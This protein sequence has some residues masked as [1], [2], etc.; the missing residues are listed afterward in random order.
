MHGWLVIDKPVGP[1]ST[2]SSSAGEAG[3]ARGRLS[4]RQG[5]AWRHARSAGERRA[6]GGAR[7]GDQARRADA[8]ADKRTIHDP[9]REETSTWTRKESGCALRVRPSSPR[10]RRCCALHGPIEQVPPLTRRWKVGGRR[11]YD[12]ASRGGS[13]DDFTCGDRAVL[14]ILSRN[15]EEDCRTAVEGASMR[16]GCRTPPQCAHGPP[17]ASGRG[18][19][20]PRARVSKGTNIR[21]LARDMPMPRDGGHVTM[22]RRSRPAPSRSHPRFRWTNWPNSLR[23]ASLN[24]HSCR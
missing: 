15:Q 7:R 3:A 6:A 4:R 22:L 9:L 14:Q 18:S 20:H 10:S 21:S 12:L 11:A 16:I 8:D 24:R 23:P 13:G 5:R 19:G 17:P 2:R 1:G